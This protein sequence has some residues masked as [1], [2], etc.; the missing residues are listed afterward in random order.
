MVHILAKTTLKTRTL[1]M[2][3]HGMDLSTEIVKLNNNTFVIPDVQRKLLPN[4]TTVHHHIGPPESKARLAAL[5]VTNSNAVII[6]VG[7]GRCTFRGPGAGPPR[8]QMHF[9]PRLLSGTFRFF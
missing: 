2:R 6:M 3:Q 4:G 8:V 5:P 1:V 7:R 9:T